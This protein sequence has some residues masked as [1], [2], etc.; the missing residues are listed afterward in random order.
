MSDK[1]NDRHPAKQ[2]ERKTDEHP[3]GNSGGNAGAGRS[4][5]EGMGGEKPSDGQGAGSQTPGQPRR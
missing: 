5:K 1:G 4:G 3:K 2:D